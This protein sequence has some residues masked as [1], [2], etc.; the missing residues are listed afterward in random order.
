MVEFGPAFI[1]RLNKI[2]PLNTS[3]ICEPTLGSLPVF[4]DR[5]ADHDKRAGTYRRAGQQ[6]SC[7]NRTDVAFPFPAHIS[8]R[9]QIQFV[10]EMR[11]YFGK[12]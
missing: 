11:F 4:L 9:R 5:L 12:F 8:R 10:P 3:G 7:F 6:Q 2:N 1:N